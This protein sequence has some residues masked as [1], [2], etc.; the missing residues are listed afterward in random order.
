MT[1]IGTPETN[2][3]GVPSQVADIEY[4]ISVIGLRSYAKC[5]GNPRSANVVEMKT[6]T[7]IHQ[8][9]E[10]KQT[11]LITPK[12]RMQLR[13][14]SAISTGMGV[15]CVLAARQLLPV[16]VVSEFALILDSLTWG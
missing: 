5:P 14:H 6:F 12:R 16:Q 2:M 15:T 7:I 9:V 13:P 11:T 1:Q 4:L 10:N 3:S 8:A